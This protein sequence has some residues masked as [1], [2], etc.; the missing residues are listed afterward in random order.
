MAHVRMID[1][2]IRI[3]R[4]ADI[5]PYRHIWRSC[6]VSVGHFRPRSRGTEIG[7]SASNTASNTAMRAILEGEKR[8]KASDSSVPGAGFE[9]THPFG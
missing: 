9:P 1:K 3:G 7:H 4:V 2:R 5:R 8:Q 6:V